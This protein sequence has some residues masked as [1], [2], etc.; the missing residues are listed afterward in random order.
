MEAFALSTPTSS[1]NSKAFLESF[2][3][4]ARDTPRKKPYEAPA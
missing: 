4:E 2:K 3:D 1:S